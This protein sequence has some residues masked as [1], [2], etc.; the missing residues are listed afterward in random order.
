MKFFRKYLDSKVS[1]IIALI[2]IIVFISWEFTS[3][4]LKNKNSWLI[5]VG[6]IE[7]KAKDWQEAYKSL[8]KDPISSQE[9]LANPSY[10]KKRVLEDMI[11][12]ALI[13]QEAESIGFSICINIIPCVLMILYGCGCRSCGTRGRGAASS[14]TKNTTNSPENA[15][16]KKL[17]WL[18]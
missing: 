17:S 7:Y 12:S 14:P 18:L 11:K 4:A 10:A 2:I 6:K 15:S 3:S 16:N 13:L 9:A 5:K 8:T 1:K